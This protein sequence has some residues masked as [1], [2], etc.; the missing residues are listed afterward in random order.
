MDINVLTSKLKEASLENL[1]KFRG[2]LKEIYSQNYAPDIL[3]NEKEQ[4]KDLIDSLKEFQENSTDKI[5]KYQYKLMADYL[6]EALDRT[7]NLQ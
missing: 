6:S 3:W 5:R 7:K 1:E 4:I 2:V